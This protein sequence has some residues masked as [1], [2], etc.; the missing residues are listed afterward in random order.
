[1]H[2]SPGW[3]RVGVC[4]SARS[5]FPSGSRAGP[6]RVAIGVFVANLLLVAGLVS[7]CGHTT[8]KITTRRALDALPPQAALSA[9]VGGDQLFLKFREGDKET[10]FQADWKSRGLEHAAENRFRFTMLTLVERPPADIEKKAASFREA[11][12]APPDVYRAVL[13]KAAIRLAPTGAGEGT[14]IALGDREFVAYRDP[15][16]GAI[17]VPSASSPPD[18]R[19]VRRVNLTEFTANL[20]AVIEE[21]LRE[22]GLPQR[23]FL[24]V[25][26][27]PGKQPFYCVFDLDQKVVVIATW[28][29]LTDIAGER[30]SSGQLWRI[31]WAGV[32]EG[33]LFSLVKNP[34][35]FA[36]RTVN[37]VGQTVGLI[38]RRRSWPAPEVPPVATEGPGMDL[39]AFEAKLDSML[40][41][42]RARG[43]IR[44]LIDGPRFFPVFERRL[45][46]A[47]E[48]LHLRICIWD[49]DDVAVS[50]ADR[51]RRRSL[52][53][54][55]TRVLVDRITTLTSG[56]AP[57]GGMM[58]EG[59]QPPRAIQPYMRDGSRV[60][61]RNFLNGMFMGDHSKVLIVDR[62]FAYIGG[63]NIGREYRH[64]WH[65][66]MVELEGPIIG[67]FER[68]FE[69]AWGH[70]SVLGDLAYAGAYLTA[71]KKYEGP[72]QREDYI[73]LRP[74]YSKTL[75]PGIL[76][77]VREAIR[78]S[79]R[80]AWIE[81]PYIYDDTLVRELIAA[82]RR[83]VDVRVVMPSSGDMDATDSNNKVKANRMLEHGVRVYS[84]PGMLHTK[85][86]IVDGWAVIGSCNFNKLSLRTNY[87][88]DIATSDP[89][90]AESMRRELFEE[91][92]ARARELTD[93]LPVTG[94]DRFAE[95]LAH[96]M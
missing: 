17:V 32:V 84:Y 59:F 86:A 13:Q 74:I 42:H 79:R 94:S 41:A 73:D 53:I 72:A 37:W 44:L 95:L 23:L 82:R 91:D 43:A 96:Q 22:T 49:T 46:E 69:L 71:P 2:S 20:L 61:V 16:R 10:V 7:G 76:R 60:R 28:P 62:K 68:D 70:A 38:L 55:D 50:V 19:V 51:V 88:A 25:S 39:P 35:S 75:H 48:S 34:V 3:V 58:P 93:P 21:R 31:F 89:R 27:R 14:F 57:P 15:A 24:V 9:H 85:A 6:S 67:T 26:E 54:P 30:G 78:R 81:N 65:D 80:Y 45:D 36:G 5:D 29:G 52:E 33:Q 66:V 77:A 90:F 12:V 11:T 64:E 87:E 18:V 1:M 8:S 92:F 56:E 47:K 40:G 83:G 4:A 63:M